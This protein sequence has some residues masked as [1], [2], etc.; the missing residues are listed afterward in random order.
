MARKTRHQTEGIDCDESQR[1]LS[2]GDIASVSQYGADG[3]EIIVE[4]W[5]V[6]QNPHM[7]LDVARALLHRASDSLLRR[8]RDKRR[9]LNDAPRLGP[10][11]SWG[12]KLA[13]QNL[14]DVHRRELN[15]EF[16]IG[17]LD[18]EKRR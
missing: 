13:E 4:N 5:S 12:E 11:S 2:D 9:K 7:S 15:A 3:Y 6:Y 10:D 17:T 18:K 8:H 1:H 16:W 14:M